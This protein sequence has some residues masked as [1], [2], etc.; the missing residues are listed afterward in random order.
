MSPE[1]K[2]LA[3]YGVKNK[4]MECKKEQNLKS[5]PC[6]YPGCQR[7]GICCECLKYHRENG[8]LPACY[9]SPETE[10]TYDRSIEKFIQNQKNA[11]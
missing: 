9:F 2:P 6:T 11:Q 7:K 3:S 8:E 4:I 1:G 10:K 5:C